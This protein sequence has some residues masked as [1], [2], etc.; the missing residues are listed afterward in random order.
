MAVS[1]STKKCD[2]CGGSLVYLPEKKV[3]QCRYCGQEIVREETYDG[4][5]TIKNVARQ[6]IVDTAYRRMEQANQN[7][8]ECEKIDSSYIGTLIARICY[9]L[10]AAITPDACREE[11]ARGMFQRLGNDFQ[12]LSARGPEPDDEEEAMYEFL[13]ASDS[14]SDAFALLTLVFDTLGDSRRAESFAARIEPAKIYS[15]ECNKDLLT[16]A[17]KRQNMELAAAIVSN[18][19]N[20]DTHSA[21]DIVLDKAPDIEGKAG[22]AA[23]LLEAGAYTAQDQRRLQEYLAGGD[24]CATKAAVVVASRGT[25]ATPDMEAILTHVLSQ[26]GPEETSAVLDAVCTGSLYDSE[27]YELLE[28]AL[29]EKAE[30]AVLILS[31]IAASGQFAVLNARQL[32]LALAGGQRSVQ[33]RLAVWEALQQF[34]FDAKAVET[35]VSRYLC[36]GADASEDRRTLLE[37]LL[38]RLE[39]IPPASLERYLL[40]CTLDGAG[41]PE[42]L[43]LLFSLE[44]MRPSF[45]NGA[46]GKYLRKS[47]DEPEVSRAVTQALIEAGLTLD[48]G[49]L[50]ELICREGMDPNEKVELLRELEKNGCTVRADA[51]SVY[52]ERCCGSYSEALFAYLFEKT[53]SISERALANFVLRCAGESAAKAR[54]AATLAARQAAPFGTSV[55]QIVHLSHRV[56]CNLMQAYLLTTA[57]PYETSSALLQA[58]S[59]SARLAGEIQ[60]DGSTVRLKKYVKENRG[61]LTPLTEQ[62]CEDNRL[63]S[64][65]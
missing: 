6:C 51:L 49:D 7:L 2:S 10:I 28:Y 63:F 57:D 42:L 37:Q 31:K 39:V 8:T 18:T 19:A 47:P 55:C 4:L 65:F 53:S 64:M 23:R 17:L 9:R 48:A 21:L 45:Y 56:S 26:T 22:M 27:L 24:S 30:K 15:R 50:N 34:R 40:T 13:A 16:F 54:N 33:E 5:F 46:L 61:S 41:K 12:T 32:E 59:A 58:M 60:V 20:L 11:E 44:K 1:Y 25:G 52:L 29:G 62:L 3:W 38:P 36:E 14:A 35:V 43:R